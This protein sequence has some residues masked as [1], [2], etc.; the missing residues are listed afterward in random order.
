MKYTRKVYMRI[1]CMMLSVIMLFGMVP[2]TAMASDFIAPPL[3]GVTGNGWDDFGGL[4]DGYEVDAGPIEPDANSPESDNSSS[5]GGISD[6]GD[7]D[8]DN[9]DTIDGSQGDSETETDAEAEG[10][11]ESAVSTPGNTALGA[12]GIVIDLPPDVLADFIA[13][14]ENA[15]KAIGS[16][17]IMPFAGVGDT[18]TITWSW[19]EAADFNA[20]GYYVNQ[21]PTISLSTVRPSEGRPFC[22]QFGPDPL[23]GGKY[24]AAAYSH[25]TILKLL[26]AH[27]EGKASA[28]GVQLAVWSITNSAS[29]FATH[30]EAQA[31]LSAANSVSTDGYTLLRWTTSGSYQPF[32]TLERVSDDWVLKILKQCAET[33]KLLKDAEFSVVGPGVNL[34]ELKTDSKGQIL[35]DIPSPGG[36][37]TVTETTPPPGYF[38]AD[39]ASQTVTINSTN[40]TGT[41]TF[42]NEPDNP[43]DDEP[44]QSS[45]RVEVEVEVE[46]KVDV[47][48]EKEFEYSRAYG[49]FT[50]RKH[51]Q[52]GKSLDGALF[53]IEVRFTDGTVL[54]E[55]NW[56]VDNGA[57]LFSYSHPENVRPDRA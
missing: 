54:R 38:P 30:P 57:R 50:I 10:I 25:P 52:D 35:V 56:E 26:I 31:A 39:P 14:M 41:V 13:F 18:G 42:K 20:G 55:T 8:A 34:T 11:E 28:V 7:F 5:G 17:Q 24:T 29:A 32:F 46:T 21:I 47:R 9:L 37:Y 15:E 3:N 4:P 22:A 23:T 19:G 12:S 36:T 48:N 40:P 51:D 6:N 45:F 43:P 27:S 1:V 44:G 16:L 49:Q 53:N 33:G 2:T